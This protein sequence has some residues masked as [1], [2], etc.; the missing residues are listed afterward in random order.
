MNPQFVCVCVCVS[1]CKMLVGDSFVALTHS[2]IRSENHRVDSHCPW[3]ER[4]MN[5]YC[6]I[7]HKPTFLFYTN[8]FYLSL[9][10]GI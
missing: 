8:C 9:I 6:D 3:K 2:F 1:I 10:C 7:L 5:T 4:A